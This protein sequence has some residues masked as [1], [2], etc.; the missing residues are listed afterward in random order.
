M[1][2][3][4]FFYAHQRSRDSLPLSVG[5]LI[6]GSVSSRLQLMEDELKDA[7]LL[8]FANKQDLPNALS[9]GELTEKLSLNQ[10]RNKV[11]STSLKKK[12]PIYPAWF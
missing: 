4:C 12:N 10:Y 3:Q 2:C 8:V 1:R 6:S 7:V 11:V 5:V 9:V